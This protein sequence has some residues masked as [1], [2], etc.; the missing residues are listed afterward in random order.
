[1]R[2]CSTAADG[3]HIK[4]KDQVHPTD[5]GVQAAHFIRVAA[6]TLNKA[7]HLG[8]DLLNVAIT[9]ISLLTHKQLHTHRRLLLLLLQV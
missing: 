4:Q 6:L 2:T 7:N 1:M 5:A 9:G 8:K 3:K